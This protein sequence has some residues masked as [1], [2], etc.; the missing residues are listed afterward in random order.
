MVRVLLRRL[1]VDGTSILPYA[2]LCLLCLILYVP[3][4]AAIPP[5]DRDEARFT[6]A[7][8]QMLETG[9]FVRIR[10]QEEARNKKPIG[11]YWLQAAAVAALSSPESAAIW[12]YR[13]PSALA[14]SAAV[15]LIFGFGARLF[16][17]RRAGFI[18]AA[19]T[20]SALGVVIEAHLAKTDAALLAAVVAGQGALGL[21][22]IATRTG[23]RVGRPLPLLFWLAEA[24]A[25]L[26]KGPPGPLLALSTAGCLSVADRDFLWVKGLRPLA[27]VLI[28]AAIVAPWLI[29]VQSATAGHFI[30]DSLA[31]DLLPKLVGAQEA[32]GA[33]PGY[34]LAVVIASFWPG[35]LFIVPGLM[36][37]WRQRRAAA[38]RFLLAW[39]GPA[40]IFFELVPTK[41]PHYVLP[42]YPALALLAGGALAEGLAKNLVGPARFVYSAVGVL[43]GAVT[44]ALGSALLIL[45][46]WFGGIVSPAVFVAVLAM[47]GLASFLLFRNLQPMCAAGLV[48]AISAAFVVPAGLA[49]IPELDYL[50][51]SR[52]AAAALARH[53]PGPGEAVLSVGY[54]EPSIVFLL[55]T[56]TR[57]VTAD[58]GDGQLAGAGMALVNDRYA[59]E[60]RRSLDRRGLTARALER[61]EGLDYSAGGGK[62]VLTLYRL[63]PG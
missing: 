43:W 14:A 62:L 30:S 31:H 17:S 37:G 33:P 38:G 8:R 47:L 55:G 58:P 27:G 29:A 10:F 7:T 35:S 48:G 51:P 18:A 1:A 21:V 60:F 12:P 57:L 16:D 53:P 19:L 59:E 63:E 45:P 28:M 24:L 22:Y 32:H 25:I 40:W 42:L 5:L 2:V 34:Y 6:Q 52:S 20:A 26:L 11:I 54:S 13:L 61:V 50:W 44:I 46:L 36:W 15:L 39:L 41:L 3:G 56:A 49:V 4:L 9:D 23:R